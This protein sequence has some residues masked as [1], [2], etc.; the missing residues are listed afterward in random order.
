MENHHLYWTIPVHMAIFHSKL[1]VITRLG[2]HH[3]HP[4]ADLVVSCF[5]SHWDPMENQPPNPIFHHCQMS[6]LPVNPINS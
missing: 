1:L 3:E 4:K 6:S 5:K 2:N